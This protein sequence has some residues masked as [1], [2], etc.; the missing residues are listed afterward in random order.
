MIL[1]RLETLDRELEAYAT[2]QEPQGVA[3]IQA[4]NVRIEEI[5]KLVQERSPKLEPLFWPIDEATAPEDARAAIRGF[6]N[7]LRP[8]VKVLSV[9]S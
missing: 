5:R 6:L 7:L 2:A 8:Y 3:L 9:K 4:A 1:E